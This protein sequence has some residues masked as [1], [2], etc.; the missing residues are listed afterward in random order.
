MMMMTMTTMMKMMMTTLTMVMMTMMM[1]VMIRI[2][3]EHY[4]GAG[5]YLNVL[6]LLDLLFSLKQC[7]LQFAVGWVTCLT[8]AAAAAAAAAAVLETSCLMFSESHPHCLE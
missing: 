3:R 2:K 7:W 4:S 8:A 5:K 1:I 6:F